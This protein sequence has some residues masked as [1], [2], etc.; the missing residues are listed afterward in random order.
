MSAIPFVEFGFS[1]SQ[2]AFEDHQ[3]N[4]AQHR[5]LYDWKKTRE[6]LELSGLETPVFDRKTIRL[7]LD[8]ILT[9]HPDLKLSRTS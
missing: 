5:T 6:E 2:N 1:M 9:H 4:A 7:A 8:H 3:M